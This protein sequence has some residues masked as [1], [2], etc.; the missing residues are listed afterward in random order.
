MFEFST[1]SIASNIVF[2]TEPHTNYLTS[3]S[4][5]TISYTMELGIVGSTT[6]IM[7]SP[8]LITS[9]TTPLLAKPQKIKGDLEQIVDILNKELYDIL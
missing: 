3:C 8:H 6:Y 7:D 2:T 5:D 9:S 4:Y 1:P